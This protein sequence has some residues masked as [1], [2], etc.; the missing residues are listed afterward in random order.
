MNG[1]AELM[2]GLRE[3]QVVAGKY[4]LERLLGVGGMGLVVAAQNT[5]LDMPVALKF[6]RAEAAVNSDAAARFLREAQAAVQIQSENVVR[7]FDVG[8][9]DTG[10]PYMVMEYLRGEDLGKLVETRGALPIAEA[11]GYVLQ[12]C[13]AVAAAHSLGIVHRDLK[14]ANLFLTTRRDGRPLVKVLDFGI[15]KALSGDKGVAAANLTA[16][17]AV[18]GSPAYMSPEQMRSSKRVDTRTDIWALGMIAHELLTGKPAF[19]AQTMPELIAMITAD[20]PTPLRTVRPDAPAELESLVLRCLA[21][22][23]EERVQTIGDLVQLLAPFAATGAR[24]LSEASQL[25][26]AGAGSGG[27][28][29]AV[30][31]TGAAWGGTRAMGAVPRTRGPAVAVGSL[32]GVAVLAVAAFV[33]WPKGGKPAGDSAAV[34]ASPGGTGSVAAPEKA[35]KPV[36]N[37]PPAPEKAEA[38]KAVLPAATEAP[39]LEPGAAAAAGSPGPN[40]SAK[41]PAASEPPRHSPPPSSSAPSVHA[42][43]SPPH[44]AKPAVAA[45]HNDSLF[46]DSK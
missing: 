36:E 23:P 13:D 42:T 10:E 15:S 17:S 16:T 6:L 11:I 24:T 19:D 4:R 45:K 46:D 2:N 22:N 5:A 1:G 34:A 39:V 44:S 12:A 37:A 28:T 7:V 41:A 3:G 9:L 40:A 8:T 25:R 38:E 26:P 21:K 20:P 30:S 14:P 35:N 31:N 29:G 43:L 27:G 18:M 32:L 33:L